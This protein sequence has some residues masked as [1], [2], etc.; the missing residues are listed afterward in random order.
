[1][2]FRKSSSDEKRAGRRAQ[3]P[4]A[5]SAD[6]E[7]DAESVDPLLDLVREG[8][9]LTADQFLS[10]LRAQRLGKR[11]DPRIDIALPVL[12]TGTDVS[13]RP[14]DQRVMTINISRRGALLEGIHGMLRAGDVI[15]LAR[16]HKREQFRVAWVG[17][18]SSPATGQIGVAAVDPN[19]SFWSEVLEATAESGLEMASLRGNAPGDDSARH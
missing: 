15:G 16:L 1:M 3:N 6:P 9:S 8:P 19:T 14:L 2:K 18:D 7:R 12:L 11:R 10:D 5:D 13:G 4:S 17:D